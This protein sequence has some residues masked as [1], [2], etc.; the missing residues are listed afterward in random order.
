MGVFKEWRE[1][2]QALRLTG[3]IRDVSSAD[4]KNIH[5]ALDGFKKML[6]KGKD[7][8]VAVPEIQNAMVQTRLTFSPETVP[9]RYELFLLLELIPQHNIYDSFV[10]LVNHVRQG[11]PVGRSLLVLADAAREERF[12]KCI[13]TSHAIDATLELFQTR[14]DEA[15]VIV[16][17]IRFLDA[18]Y[19]ISGGEKWQETMATLRAF[20]DSKEFMC[21]VNGNTPYYEKVITRL[22]VMLD[23]ITYEERRFI[24]PDSAF[25][26]EW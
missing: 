16:H 15:D 2:K 4:G 14:S 19:L 21:N 13:L 8:S 22:A 26:R 3:L 18:F 10:F 5:R 9:K 20:L 11:S 6:E 23:R 25:E 1:T 12:R 17:A 7:I 24:I